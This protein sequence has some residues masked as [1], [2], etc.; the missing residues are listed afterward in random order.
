[1]RP[2]TAKLRHE[3]SNPNPNSRVVDFSECRHKTYH[4]VQNFELILN[5]LVKNWCGRRRPSY[6]MND[7]TLTLIV[8][9]WTSQIVDTNHTIMCRILSWFWIYLWKI[10]EEKEDEVTTSTIQPLGLDPRVMDFSECWHKTYHHVR[11]FEL[12]L[13]IFLKNWCGRR[14]PSYDMNDPTLTLTLGLWT[15]QNVDIK[16]TIMCRIMSWFWIYLWKIDAVEDDQVTTW[17]IQP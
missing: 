17:T 5:I 1:M 10:D 12:I 4:H 11:N 15:F 3:R 14:R 2:K 7:P 16:Y 13:S 9:L 8:G 6:N